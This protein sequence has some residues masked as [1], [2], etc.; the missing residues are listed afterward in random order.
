MFFLGGFA[1]TIEKV[2]C[3]A[4]NDKSVPASLL[5]MVIEKGAS[6]AARW[7]AARMHLSVY[8]GIK[9]YLT[10]FLALLPCLTISMPWAGTSE[11]RKSCAFDLYTSW[12]CKL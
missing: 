7:W 4:I 10:T 3:E 8:G 12:P 2:G 11:R 5:F 6:L 9:L 1:S